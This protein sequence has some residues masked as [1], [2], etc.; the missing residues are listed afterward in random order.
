M[1][2]CGVLHGDIA[3]RNIA[4]AASHWQPKGMEGGGAAGGAG[5][6]GGGGAGAGAGGGGGGGAGGGGGGGGGGGSGEGGSAWQ[7]GPCV[8]LLDFGYATPVATAAEGSGEEPEELF[9][10][11]RQ[12]L[13]QLL[14]CGPPRPPTAD[15]A[16]G[17]QAAAA[18]TSAASNASGDMACNQGELL[19]RA[20][21][22]DVCAADPADGLVAATGPSTFPAVPSCSRRQQRVCL[23]PAPPPSS[24]P[25]ALLGGGGWRRQLQP[26]V[27]RRSQHSLAQHHSAR[28]ASRASSA[29]RRL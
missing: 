23:L 26:L 12:E 15:A 8:V 1:H 19:E 20:V 27:P 22:P 11:E 21:S 2:A 7:Q 24:R 5:A 25:G 16:W 3:L 17:G 13:Q 9:R 6:G 18:A 29:V 10:S 4:L 28:S 14:E